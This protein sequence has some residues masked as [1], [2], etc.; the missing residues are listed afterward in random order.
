MLNEINKFVGSIRLV[1]AG[2]Q[3]RGR[4]GPAARDAAQLDLGAALDEA[5][6]YVRDRMVGRQ[7]R[8]S[9]PRVSALGRPA[10]FGAQVHHGPIVRT[11]VRPV[12]C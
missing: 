6:D 5:L 1:T 8:I 12:W 3:I 7:R 11:A 2:L 4:Q 9:L 10:R